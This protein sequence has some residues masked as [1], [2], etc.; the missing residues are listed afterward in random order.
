M[1]IIEATNI[2]KS[3][4]LGGKNM[5]I[6]KDINLN[7]KEGEFVAIVGSS[8]SGKSTL[9]SI[10]AGLDKPTSGK[11]LID[12]KRID[13]LSEDEMAEFRNKK[14]GF[15]FQS[16]FLVPSL[17]AYE[18]VLLPMEISNKINEKKINETLQA[19]GMDHRKNNYPLQ[20]SGGERQRIAIARALINEPRIIFAD[21]PTG[22]LD[23]TNGENIM[24]I[25]TKL[26]KDKKITLIIV[27]HEK[28]VSKLADRIIEIKDGKII[29][30]K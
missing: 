12:K 1:N 26:K 22:N 18:N 8:G 27:T 20:L 6:L 15:I 28:K 25:L 30:S 2:N 13:N 5:Q 10:I 4:T 16:F 11:I 29:N 21:E 19:V 23:S 17:T 7:I 3:F 9:L 24:K 14:I